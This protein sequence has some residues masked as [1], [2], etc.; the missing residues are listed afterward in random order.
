M[1]EWLARALALTPSPHTAE[2]S[3]EPA[4]GI[5]DANGTPLLYTDGR[6]PTPV[7]AVAHEGMDS[8]PARLS[9]R[10]TDRETGEW[11]SDLRN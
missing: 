4:N 1:S 6:A 10:W 3:P 5:N 9:M 8:E 2:V 11:H 7:G